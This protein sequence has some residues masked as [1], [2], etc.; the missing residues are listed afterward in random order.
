VFL[1]TGYGQTEPGTRVVTG[2]ICLL[3]QACNETGRNR[4]KQGYL[5]KKN[6]VD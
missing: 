2:P 3:D 1:K 4:P 6:Y 5:N